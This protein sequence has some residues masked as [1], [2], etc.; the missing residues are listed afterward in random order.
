M[1]GRGLV[2]IVH[3][4]ACGRA[5]IAE[6]EPEESVFTDPDCRR[7]LESVFPEIDRLAETAMGALDRAWVLCPS[8]N[9]ANVCRSASGACCLFCQARFGTTNPRL[10]S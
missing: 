7:K 6:R 8:L 2:A 4:A 3:A 5:K 1:R 10:Q 9:G